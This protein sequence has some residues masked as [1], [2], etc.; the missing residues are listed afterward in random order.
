MDC[1]ASL[2]V[3]PASRSKTQANKW[4]AQLVA[5]PINHLKKGH[6]FL[7]PGPRRPAGRPASCT[8]AAPSVASRI[9]RR[10]RRRGRHHTARSPPS[11][12]DQ[13][14]RVGITPPARRRSM[15]S[16]ASSLRATI[17]PPG[18][19][20]SRIHE[21][22]EASA[23][24][25]VKVK[26]CKFTSSRFPQGTKKKPPSHRR[27]KLRPRV[28]CEHHRGF[29]WSSRT[30]APSNRRT[31]STPMHDMHANDRARRA[32]QRPRPCMHVP[33]FLSTYSRARPS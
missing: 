11:S 31:A 33:R 3:P 14:S 17:S 13:L 1:I 6:L 12:P 19:L 7:H 5:K 9:V 2:L 30:L 18:H 29:H 15:L 10:L 20:A 23:D 4:H 8:M 24:S 16:I 27:R 26:D 21:D 22:E 25:P 28:V 32:A